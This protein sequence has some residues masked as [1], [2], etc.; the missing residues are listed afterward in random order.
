MREFH[1][2]NGVYLCPLL[3]GVFTSSQ[4]L[5]SGVSCFIYLEAISILLSYNIEAFIPEWIATIDEDVP[6]VRSYLRS[7]QFNVA[8]MFR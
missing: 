8:Y 1:V 7:L 2:I 3:G 5:C 4:N 6:L